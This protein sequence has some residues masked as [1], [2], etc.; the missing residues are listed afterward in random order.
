MNEGQVL[1]IRDQTQW[2]DNTQRVGWDLKQ[3]LRRRNKTG[4]RTNKD[5]RKTKIMEKGEEK[6]GTAKTNSDQLYSV[7]SDGCFQPG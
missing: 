5:K 2:R 4:N 1:R 6:D 7:F 3:E